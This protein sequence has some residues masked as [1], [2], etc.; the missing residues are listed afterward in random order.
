MM[1]EPTISK[2]RDMKLFVMAD[3]LNDILKNPDLKLK[4]E[5]LISLLVDSQWNEHQ[6]KYLKRMLKKATLSES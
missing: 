4:P 5:E 6:S 1:V 2:L 3:T